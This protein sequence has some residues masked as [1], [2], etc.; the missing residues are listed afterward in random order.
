MKPRTAV[1]MVSI[2]VTTVLFLIAVILPYV[3]YGPTIILSPLQLAVGLSCF[4]S[5]F[6]LTVV[7]LTI[8]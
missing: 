8:E 6:W 3:V 2:I 4:L 5:M 1:L 7:L